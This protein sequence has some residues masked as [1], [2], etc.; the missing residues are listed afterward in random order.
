VIDN[1]AKEGAM[2]PHRS[3]GPDLRAKKAEIF[4]AMAAVA[5]WTA[6]EFPLS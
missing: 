4:A 2:T 6:L 5:V 1:A 3:T